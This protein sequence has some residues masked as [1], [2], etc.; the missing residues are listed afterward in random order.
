[1]QTKKAPQPQR[2]RY[3]L[4]QK[5]SFL[6]AYEKNGIGKA[7][8]LESLQPTQISRGTFQGWI[9]EKEKLFAAYEKVEQTYGNAKKKSVYKDNYWRVKVGVVA[10]YKANQQRKRI[11]RIR[12]TGAV[13]SATAVVLR[14]EILEKHEKGKI[15]LPDEELEALKIFQGSESWARKFSAQQDWNKNT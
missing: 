2:K 13:I 6:R 14:D 1:M 9:R 15:C 3:A 5:V 8:F 10:F 12:I 11:D 4:H 7:K